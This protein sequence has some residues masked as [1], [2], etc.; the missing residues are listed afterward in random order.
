MQVSD[1]LPTPR[2]WQVLEYDG[3]RTQVWRTELNVAQLRPAFSSYPPAF[4]SAASYHVG[5]HPTFLDYDLLVDLRE[6]LGRR[7]GA[8]KGVLSIEPFTT[9]ERPLTAEE[10]RR[11]VSVA[12][13]FSPNERE[14][15]SIVGGEAPP[16]EVVARLAA[17]GARV[18]ALRRGPDGAVVHRADTGETWEVPA[19]EGAAE[20]DPTGCGNAFCGGFLASWRA[21]EGLLEAG[22][23]V[24]FFCHA[25]PPPPSR[26]PADFFKP[27]FSIWAAGLRRGQLHGESPH[28][29]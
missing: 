24:R 14:A 29:A 27:V 8:G 23:W 3:R 12:D 16:L 22:L 9:A 18:V 6:A 28:A 17:A 26:S 19:V 25:R 10:L 20:V 21:G 7:P 4:Q 15:R 11:L 13:I 5:I 1:T 2:A